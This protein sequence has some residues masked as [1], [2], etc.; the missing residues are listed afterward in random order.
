MKPK[1]DNSLYRLIDLENLDQN[2]MWFTSIQRA[3]I[4]LNVQRVQL[5]WPFKK[6]YAFKGRWKIILED[7]SEVP[8]KY[9][10]RLSINL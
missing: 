9:I 10:D 2:N 3:A 4:F 5:E 7:G 1:N 8:Y 6:G